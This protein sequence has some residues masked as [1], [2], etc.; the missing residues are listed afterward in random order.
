MHLVYCVSRRTSEAEKRYHS[1]RLEL[2]AV[3]WAGEK[4]RMFLLGIN[5][6]VYTDCRAIV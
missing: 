4:L 6:A 5:F 3:V 2:M 1:R